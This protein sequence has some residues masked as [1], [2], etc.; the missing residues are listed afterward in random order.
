MT[1]RV[2]GKFVACLMSVVL[3]VA[4][5]C[6]D[7][8]GAM[9]YVNGR[10]TLNGNGILRTSA[11]FSGDKLQVPTDS[12][13]TIASAGTSVIVAPGSSI[14]FG[15]DQVRLA[16]RSAVSITTSKG[17]AAVIDKV[18]I[19]PASGSGKYQ[20]ARVGGMVVIAAK[21]GV[22]NVA[23]GAMMRTVAEGAST[24]ITDPEP[25]P[26][27]PGSIP[28]PGA[29]PGA[30]SMPT[31]LAELLALAALGAAAGVAYATTGSPSS[32]VH[33]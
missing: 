13:V 18:K 25:M 5:A 29:G 9:M 6:A 7:T 21:Q 8:Q 26:Q 4:I 33:P 30:V 27:K 2:V 23:D 14:E 1:H 32:P 22:V 10:A 19:V 15:G 11:I 3:P 24:T 12:S 16:G 20:V 31:W 17:M 28:T